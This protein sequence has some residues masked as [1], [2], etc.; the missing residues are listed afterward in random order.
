MCSPLLIA[1]GVQSYSYSAFYSRNHFAFNAIGDQP[2]SICLGRGQT[3]LLLSTRTWQRVA[4]DTVAMLLHLNIRRPFECET[5]YK[6]VVDFAPSRQS[7][8]NSFVYFFHWCALRREAGEDV[9]RVGGIA[10]ACD[11]MRKTN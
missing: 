2:I 1:I 11:H 9:T 6:F 10:N 8:F 5:Q 4:C 3:I 7:I